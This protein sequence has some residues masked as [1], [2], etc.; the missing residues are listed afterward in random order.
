[1]TVRA[2]GEFLPLDVRPRHGLRGDFK[3]T[4]TFCS[5]ARMTSVSKLMAA[6][7]VTGVV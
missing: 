5:S 6:F 4:R 3:V 1:M 7:R 2:N